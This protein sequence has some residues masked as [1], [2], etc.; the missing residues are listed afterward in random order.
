M[1]AQ[2][3][4]LDGIR[5]PEYLDALT[6]PQMQDAGP[7]LILAYALL[8]IGCAIFLFRFVPYFDSGGQMP[9]AGMALYAP[10]VAFSSLM[11]CLYFIP[12]ETGRWIASSIALLYCLITVIGGVIAERQAN[13]KRRD[14]H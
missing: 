3:E 1:L 8:L 9:W 7:S 5:R 13:I 11:L 12:S 6:F 2:V 14:Q 4:Y 10:V